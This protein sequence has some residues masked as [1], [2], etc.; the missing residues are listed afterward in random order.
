MGLRSRAI[1]AQELRYYSTILNNNRKSELENG[2]SYEFTMLF[3][4]KSKVKQ[5]NIF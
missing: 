3:N 5:H 1:G 2:Q 4:V